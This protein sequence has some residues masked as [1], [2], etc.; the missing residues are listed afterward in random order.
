MVRSANYL[1]H[2]SF[3]S[4]RSFLSR[5]D[6]ASFNATPISGGS[7]KSR[8]RLYNCPVWLCV[9]TVPQPKAI[10]RLTRSETFLGLCDQYPKSTCLAKPPFRLRLVHRTV[11]S[12]SRPGDP[13]A[14]PRSCPAKLMK[15]FSF[16]ETFFIPANLKFFSLLDSATSRF[17]GPNTPP[18]RDSMGLAWCGG[19]MITCS[20]SLCP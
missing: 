2:E 4:I 19:N 15:P 17:W 9:R 14:S 12:I 5:H 7:P 8:P 6:Y 16:Y 3:S 10:K 20:A 18:G 13:S 1:I 11:S